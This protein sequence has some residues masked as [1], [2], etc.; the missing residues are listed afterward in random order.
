M[1]ALH[2]RPIAYCKIP[3]AV[4]YGRSV[5]FFCTYA[6]CSHPPGPCDELAPIKH[7][8]VFATFVLRRDT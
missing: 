3:Y 1:Q 5:G 7:L 2:F 6:S 8:K 4:H